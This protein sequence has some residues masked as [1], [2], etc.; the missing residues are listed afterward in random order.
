MGAKVRWVKAREACF[1]YVYANGTEKA[2]RLGPT[3]ADRRRGERL[4]KEVS[5]KQARGQ[6][7]LEKPKGKP[8]PFDVFAERWLR[9]KVQLPIEREEDERLSASSARSYEQQ[10]RLHLTPFLGSHDIRAF[11]VSLI[12]QLSEHYM[13]TGKPPSRR[14]REIALGTLRQILSQAVAQEIIPT[15]VVD[16]WKATRPKTRASAKRAAALAANVLDSREREHLLNVARR[17]SPDYYPFILFLAET[18]TRISEAIALSWADIDLDS[19]TATVRRKKTGGTPDEL[20]LSCRLCEVLRKALPDIAPAD[21]PGFHTPG[22]APIHYFNF[23][24]RVWVPIVK[25]AFGEGRRFTVHGLRH[26][27]ATLHLAAGTPI[28]WI[29]ARGG[30]SSAKLLLDTYGHF[31]PQEMD[32]FEDVLAPRHRNRPEQHHGQSS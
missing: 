7:G 10:I 32:G 29:Q 31:M 20:P 23:R 16:Q 5:R 26:T 14:S 28:K 1:I 4:A 13:E 3:D 19:R 15:N 22:G 18:G 12:E 30:W 9:V 24:N 8:V 2:K 21:S 6:L 27:W 25:D 17:K 11:R